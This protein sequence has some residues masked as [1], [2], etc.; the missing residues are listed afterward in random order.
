M[1]INSAIYNP[2]A[3]NSGQAGGIY[4]NPSPA[5]YPGPYGRVVASQGGNGNIFGD[6]VRGETQTPTASGFALGYGKDGDTPEFMD[7]AWSR[8]L[9]TMSPYL[10]AN[11]ISYLGS[12][13]GL[14]ND[15]LRQA[16][17]QDT[18]YHFA[19]VLGNADVIRQIQSASPFQVGGSQRYV[20]TRFR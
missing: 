15:A 11:Q 7:N 19:D 13:R 8:F 3:G 14:Y 10:N 4:T 5:R 9:A 18:G 1:P 6:V 2:F 16:Q 12:Q 17:S 20:P